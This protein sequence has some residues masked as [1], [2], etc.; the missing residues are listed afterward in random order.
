M[1]II[2]SIYLFYLVTF[3]YNLN[4]QYSSNSSGLD[5]YNINGS[6]SSSIGEVFFLQK[7]IN[8]KLDEGIQNGLTINASKKK[9]KVEV[10]IYPNPT[11]DLVQFKVQNLYYNN[12]RYSIYNA[13]GIEL[14]SGEIKN[15]TSQVSLKQFPSSVYIIKINRG[16]TE[17]RSYE[18]FKID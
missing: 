5:I 1:K 14:A 17:E 13:C 6:V 8:F 7:G 10:S 16:I 9:S 15:E 4:A 2:L 3:S 18:I 11:K 12:L